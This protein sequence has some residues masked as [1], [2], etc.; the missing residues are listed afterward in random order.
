VSCAKDPLGVGGTYKFQ[1]EGGFTKDGNPWDITGATVTLYFQ[2]PDG[3]QFSRDASGNITATT[4]YYVSSTSDL[5]QV[6]VWWFSFK[7]VLGGIT[8]PF[9][10]FS[11]R[12]IAPPSPL[13]A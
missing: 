2:R 5:D 7:V 11:R 9:A 12:V 4:T 3:T 1:P 10:P 13:A 6:G 8:A